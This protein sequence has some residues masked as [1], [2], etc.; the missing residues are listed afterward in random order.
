MPGVCRVNVQEIAARKLR[1][2]KRSL[3]GGGRVLDVFLRQRRSLEWAARPPFEDLL[4]RRLEQVLDDG[5]QVLNVLCNE[6]DFPL[7]ALPL[8]WR[9]QRLISLKLPQPV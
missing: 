2:N 8:L 4:L 9:G 6:V 1:V 5:I 7:N 3:A